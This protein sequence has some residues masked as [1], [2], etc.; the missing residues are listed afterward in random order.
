MSNETHYKTGETAPLPGTYKID[1]LVN[2]YMSGDHAI[3]EMAQGD[4]FPPSPSDNEA[5]YWKKA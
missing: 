5:A 2:G 3:I 4:P 1:G